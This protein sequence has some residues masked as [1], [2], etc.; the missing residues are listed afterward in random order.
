MASE[1]EQVD[2]QSFINDIRSYTEFK[3]ISFS[4]YKKTDV[5]KEFVKSLYKSKI[6]HAYYSGA[7]LVCAGHYMDLWEIVLLY[8]GKR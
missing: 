2:D 5:K 7:E 4:G 3:T 6:E 8:L 1:L